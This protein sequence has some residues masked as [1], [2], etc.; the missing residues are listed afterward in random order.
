MCLVNSAVNNGVILLPPSTSS[1]VAPFGPLIT[2]M[3]VTANSIYVATPGG[4]GT[5]NGSVDYTLGSHTSA[6]FAGIGSNTWY[7][8]SSVA[9]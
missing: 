5:V 9:N 3:N 1:S 6:Q 8:V 7:L 2:V 4:T